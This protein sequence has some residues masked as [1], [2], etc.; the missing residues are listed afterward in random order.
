[1][2]GWYHSSAKLATKL[3]IQTLFSGKWTLLKTCKKLYYP[4]VETYGQLLYKI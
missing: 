2:D 3:P 4:I 1:M